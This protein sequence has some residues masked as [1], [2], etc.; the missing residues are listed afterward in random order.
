MLDILTSFAYYQLAGVCCSFL[1]QGILFVKQLV[2][3][4]IGSKWYEQ[5]KSGVHGRFA[6]RMSCTQ[7]LG[8][9]S[10]VH[11]VRRAMHILTSK[12]ELSLM[13]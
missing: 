7:V 1:M 2:L 4:R 3:L 12:H 10:L 11:M 9:V 8:P 13:P 6:A 5:V